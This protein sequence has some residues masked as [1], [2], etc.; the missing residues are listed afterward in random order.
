[1]KRRRHVDWA[2]SSWL[3]SQ[4]Q[5]PDMEAKRGHNNKLREWRVPRMW[6]KGLL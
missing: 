5:A 4:L 6:L 1:M 2:V 3:F